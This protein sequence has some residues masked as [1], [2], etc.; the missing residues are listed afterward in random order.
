[1]NLNRGKA[2]NAIDVLCRNAGIEFGLRKHEIADAVSRWNFSHRI[3]DALKIVSHDPS[4]AHHPAI[5]VHETFEEARNHF[6]RQYGLESNKKKSIVEKQLPFMLFSILLGESDVQLADR[7][8][9][10]VEKHALSFR[11]DLRKAFYDT[12]HALFVHED[13]VIPKFKEEPVPQVQLSRK[14]IGNAEYCAENTRYKNASYYKSA[15]FLVSLAGAYTNSVLVPL[16]S[17]ELPLEVSPKEVEGLVITLENA[18]IACN[19]SRVPN[20]VRSRV[21]DMCKM[22]SAELVEHEVVGFGDYAARIRDAQKPLLDME[23]GGAYGR[24]RGIKG[25]Y[26]RRHNR[27]AR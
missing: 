22:A 6:N 16:H 27:R 10:A 11:D 12:R 18:A 20:K 1:M 14:Y 13:F 26:R 4:A 17:D 9:E 15:T 24:S 23:K 19:D 3:G 25:G 8:K 2:V 21:H 7:C 5:M